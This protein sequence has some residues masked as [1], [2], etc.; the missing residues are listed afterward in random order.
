MPAPDEEATCLP[1]HA[2]LAVG[3]N[4]QCVVPQAL[5]NLLLQARNAYDWPAGTGA[6][7]SQLA[8]I[9]LVALVQRQLTA[10]NPSTAHSIVVDVSTWAGNNSRSHG[11]ILAASSAH[12]AQMYTAI[13]RLITPGEECGGF[14]ML[15]SLPGIGLVIATKVFRFCVPREGAAVDRHASYFF[16]SL[17]VAGR[18]AATCFAREWNDRYHISSRLATYTGSKYARNKIEYFASYLPILACITQAMNALG[19]FYTCAAQA[20][21]KAWT[22]ADVEMAAYYWWARNG[23]S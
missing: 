5:V 13:S 10:L 19:A 23:P 9:N 8:I 4:G 18:G 14:D 6:T 2:R 12:R 15:C 7:A 22:P 3:V 20:L 1:A 16:N 21:G 11:Q 17:Q